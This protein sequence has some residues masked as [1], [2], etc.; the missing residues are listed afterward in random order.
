VAPGGIV[1]ADS[2]LTFESSTLLLVDSSFSIGGDFTLDVNST[3]NG[4]G[5]GYASNGASPEC[6]LG[7]GHGTGGAHGGSTAAAGGSYGGPARA[8]C[9]DYSAPVLRGSGGRSSSSG[10]AG[11]AGGGA[12]HLVVAGVATI[13]GTIS[14]NGLIGKSTPSYGCSSRARTGGGAGGSIWIQA[15]TFGGSGRLEATGGAAFDYGGCSWSYM[16]TGGSGGRI[17]VFAATS[18]FTGRVEASSAGGPHQAVRGPAGTVFTEFGGQRLLTIDNGDIGSTPVGAQTVIRCDPECASLHLDVI[19]GSAFGMLAAE[20]R[21][22]LLLM[23]NPLFS[24][25]PERYS[26]I[27]ERHR[28]R[29]RRC[30]HCRWPDGEVSLSRRLV[31][32]GSGHRNWRQPVGPV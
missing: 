12:L 18:T 3:L 7:S 26:A 22:R 21:A 31:G 9:G 19:A 11:G 16:G 32:R 28:R 13:D 14:V 8:G 5:A 15:A 1:L 17:A 6:V 4:A 23:P 29:H 27:D 20:V 2:D 30:A 25:C 24:A 10:G